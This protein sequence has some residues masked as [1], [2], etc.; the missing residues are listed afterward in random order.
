MYNQTSRHDAFFASVGGV[1]D[2]EVSV[3]RNNKRKNT[4][5]IN[6]CAT[7]HTGQTGTGEPTSDCTPDSK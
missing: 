6:V 7:A 3:I 2:E 4:V 5:N 1:T